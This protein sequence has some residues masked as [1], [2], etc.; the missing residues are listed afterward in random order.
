MFKELQVV[1]VNQVLLAPKVTLV[2]T[3]EMETEEQPVALGHLEN[4]ETSVFLGK[5]ENK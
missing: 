5:Q 2:G 3:A 1:P 4:K